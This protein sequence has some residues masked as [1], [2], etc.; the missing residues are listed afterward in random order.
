MRPPNLIAASVRGG[1]QPALDN[2]Q[3]YGYPQG[4]GVMQA[5]LE[6]QKGATMSQLREAWGVTRKFS[7]PLCGW[8]DKN[9]L[10]I[11]EGDLR[12]AGPQLAKPLG[13]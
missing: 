6:L 12:R 1:V 9:Q 3:Q 4:R 10:T 13:E 2:Y 8:F 7:V 11:R 5:T